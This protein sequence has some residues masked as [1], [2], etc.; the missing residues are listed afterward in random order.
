MFVN[1]LKFL[2]VVLVS[3]I[4]L[5]VKCEET[6]LKFATNILVFNAYLKRDK[7]NDNECQMSI[8]RNNIQ[9]C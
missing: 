5:N 7:I 2:Y 6:I 3:I 9:K 1:Y 8:Q 4:Y